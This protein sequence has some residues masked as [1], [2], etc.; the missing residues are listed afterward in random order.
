MSEKKI[1]SEKPKEINSSK[2]CHENKAVNS[3][4]DSFE[5]P[6]EAACSPEFEEGCYVMED[7]AEKGFVK[8]VE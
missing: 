5:I 8:G 7:E 4:N 6:N 3:N 2:M 1:N